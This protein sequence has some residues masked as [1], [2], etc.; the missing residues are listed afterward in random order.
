VYDGKEKKSIMKKSIFTILVI[1]LA[2]L[3][4]FWGGDIF[5]VKACVPED[6]HCRGSDANPLSKLTTPEAKTLK[7]RRLAVWLRGTCEVITTLHTRSDGSQYLLDDCYGSGCTDDTE[8]GGGGEEDLLLA[9][10]VLMVIVVLIFLTV[11]LNNCLRPVS[12]L[13]RSR[14]ILNS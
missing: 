11:F 2:L 1:E 5:S 10:A 3:F 4:S 13:F 7:I 14:S 8:G 6:V 9:A 12:R